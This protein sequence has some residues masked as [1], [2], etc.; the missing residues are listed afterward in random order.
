MYH[1][2]KLYFITL[3]CNVLCY[4]QTE[5]FINVFVNASIDDFPNLAFVYNNVYKYIKGRELIVSVFVQ[6]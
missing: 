5:V 1:L 6:P 2:S 4:V 3:L